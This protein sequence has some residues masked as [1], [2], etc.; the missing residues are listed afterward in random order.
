MRS[1]APLRALLA[2]LLLLLL[3]QLALRLVFP[4]DLFVW[5]ESPFMTNM[6]K[7]H[8]GVPLYTTPA[9]ANSFVYSPGLEYLTWALL[10]PLGLHLDIRFCRLVAVAVGLLAAWLAARSAVRIALVPAGGTPPAR[11]VWIFAGV[12]TLVVFKNLTAD[13]PHPDN[14]HM[15]H[16]AATFLLGVEALRTRSVRWA[17]AAALVAGLGPLA[18]QVAAGGMVGL[19]GA[20]LLSGRLPGRTLA[21]CAGVGAAA[22][23]ACLALLLVPE[24]SSFYTVELLALHPVAP[25]LFELFTHV[26]F[27]PHRLLLWVGGVCAVWWIWRPDP[28]LRSYLLL[29]LGLGLTEVLP[30]LAGH[31]KAMGTWN[32]LVIIDLWLAVGLAP[33]L[34]RAFGEAARVDGPGTPDAIGRRA[35]VLIGVVLLLALIPTRLPPDPALRGYCEQ[36]DQLVRRDL[37]R[38]R[39]VLVAHGA[40]FGIRN[41]ALGVPL[42]RANSLVELWVGGQGHR[43][44]TVRRLAEAHYDRIYL[45]SRWYGEAFE[46]ARKR[47]YRV[48]GRIPEVPLR[49]GGYSYGFQQLANEVLILEPRARRRP[50]S[51][52]DRT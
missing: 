1:H 51:A 41:G 33:L 7:L 48:V 50:Q 52:N 49:Y 32:N 17:L 24:Y 22:W 29:W 19:L 10:R 18:K 16:F 26:Y 39:S 3:V 36:L 46:R 25:K 28:A 11:V 15:L 42:D 31:F 14:L 4:W 23:I 27:V 40:M 38:G 30:G 12:F 6:L 2:L 45:N 34:A 47:H 13:V 43:A 8:N 37:E 44:D 21:L 9:D 20:F 35:G 5:A